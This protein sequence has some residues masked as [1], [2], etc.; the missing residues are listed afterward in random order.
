MSKKTTKATEPERIEVAEGLPDP[1][2]DLVSD[3]V[4]FWNQV[5]HELTENGR[6]NAVDRRALARYCE[7]QAEQRKLYRDRLKNGLTKRARS[8][9]GH[10]YY[11]KRP[12]ISRLETVEGL[13]SQLEKQLGLSG[14]KTEA[15]TGT[16]NGVDPTHFLFN[17]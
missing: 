15:G 11:V 10:Y 12:E 1:P 4:K 16:S 14:K 9:K 13:L 17:K 3:A 2:F 5:M 8:N 7:L 6:E